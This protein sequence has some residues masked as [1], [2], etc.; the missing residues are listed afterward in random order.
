MENLNFILSKQDANIAMARW[1]DLIVVAQGASSTL[2]PSLSSFKISREAFE[3]LNDQNQSSHFHFHMGFTETNTLIGIFVPLDARGKERT[4]VDNYSICYYSRNEKDIFL[5]QQTISKT[6][7]SLQVTKNLTIEFKKE[8]TVSTTINSPNKTIDS[9]FRNMR[10]WQDNYLDW[11]NLCY[12]QDN[13]QSLIFRYFI[14]P[15][16]DLSGEFNDSIVEIT[17]CFLGLELNDNIVTQYLPNVIFIA[18]VDEEQA[19]LNMNDLNVTS[20]SNNTFDFGRPCPPLC[21]SDDD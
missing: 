7:Q 17:N 15:I 16:Q 4:D 14:V 9:A 2:I 18:D 20:R 3:F 12:K 6:S 1:F 21:Y 8:N 13:P 11:F 19:T 5:T 10:F